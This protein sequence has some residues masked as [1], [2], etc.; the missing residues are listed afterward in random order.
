[1]PIVSLDAK[2]VRD[3]VCPVGKAKY[4][5]YSDCITGFVL[6][7]RQ[8]GGKTYYLRYRDSH[9]TQ[10]QH[11]IGDCRSITFD[12]ARLTAQVLR[13]R[14][15]LGENPAQ[16]RKVLRQIPILA[17][18]VRDRYI[19]YIK[20]H[21]RN[22]QSTLSYLRIHVLSRFAKYRLDEI[23]TEMLSE[24]HH[25][26]RQKGYALAM[27]N[28]LPIRVKAIYNLCKRQKVPGSETNPAKE[29][30][31][32]DPNNARSRY[33]TKEETQR[34]LEAVKASENPQL[35]YLIPLY[36]LLSCR[37]RELLDSRW[38]DFD[39]ERRNWHIPMSKNGRPRN[40]PI[41]KAALEILAQ[42][43]RWD[44]CPWVIPSHRTLK[45][46]ISFFFAWDSARKRAGLP[47]VRLHDLRRTGATNLLE[48]GADIITV[49]KILGHRQLKYVQ[50]Y[51]VASE[52]RLLSAVDA[53]ANSMGTN[54]LDAQ[55]ASA[56]A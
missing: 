52:E 15:V 56:P 48:S 54:W 40:V 38:S 27:A 41:P 43:P 51:A 8:S 35:K 32:Y 47:D 16:D 4:D 49:S 17:D 10:R 39:L 45:P 31:L 28:M 19:P 24:A 9:G 29:V 42:L 12:K 20:Q 5:L 14:V 22:Y 18:V 7:I 55:K 53:A 26:M 23:T 50:V 13:S 6:E 34:L 44:G 11:K 25:D 2:L 46:I 36:I 33:L 30:K 37:K 3:A 21:G 1:M